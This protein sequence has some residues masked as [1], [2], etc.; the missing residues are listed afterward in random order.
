[1]LSGKPC[2]C[3]DFVNYLGREPICQLGHCGV[4]IAGYMAPNEPGLEGEVSQEIKAKILRGEIRVNDALA[5]KSPER[6]DDQAVAPGHIGQFEYGIKTGINMIQDRCGNFKMLI[7]NGESSPETAKGQLYSAS[8]VK[9]KNYTKL[10]DLVIEQGFS[11]HLAVALGDIAQELKLLCD[12][13]GIT[14]YYVD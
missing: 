14:Y 6:Q 7:F 3:L 4:G 8:D 2:A 1:L 9:V 13:Y 11:H 5:E 12:F 10:S